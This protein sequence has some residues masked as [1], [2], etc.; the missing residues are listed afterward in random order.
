MCVGFIA[1][2][3]NGHHLMNRSSSEAKFVVIGS[4]VPGD[5]PLYPDDDLAVFTTETGR[6]AVHKDGS[7]Y[8]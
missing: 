5:I 2:D 7:P 8:S 6:I 4:R 1:G 3:K